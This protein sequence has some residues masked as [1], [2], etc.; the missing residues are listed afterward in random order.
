MN[1]NGHEEGEDLSANHANEPEMSLEC[2]DMS[3]L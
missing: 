3:P 1:T 2:G